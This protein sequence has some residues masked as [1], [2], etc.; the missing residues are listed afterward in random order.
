[1]GKS[2]L[3]NLKSKIF[4]YGP[5]GSGKSTLGIKL[6]ESLR[7]P[8]YD[9]DEHIQSEAGMTIPEI[10]Q[11]ESEAGFRR[12]EKAQLE[13]VLTKDW[14]VIALGGGAMLDAASRKMASSAGPVL[15]LAAPFETLLARLAATSEER[16]LL[17]T[18]DADRDLGAG[19]RAL[20]AQ[21]SEHYATFPLQLDTSS[22]DTASLVWEAQILLGTFHVS[23][24]AS[25]AGGIPED[26][27]GLGYDVR[28]QAGGLPALGEALRVRGLRGPIA[29][30]SDENVAALHLH[31]PLKS[32]HEAGYPSQPIVVPAGEDSKDIST[33]T[34]LWEAF[35]E[36]G[37]ERGSTVVALG[38]GVVGDLAGFAAASYKRGVPWVA[39]PTTL[40]AMADSSLGGKTG[41]D[42]RQGKNLVG[43]FH[44]PRL[45]LSDPNTLDTLPE[46]ELRAG[47]AEV[48][49]AGIIGDPALFNKC[50]EGWEAVQS[51]WDE[52]VRRA[53]AVK[54]RVIE[55]D[56]FEHGPRAALNLGHTVGHAVEMAAN[57]AMKHGQAV[58]IGMVVEAHLA[59]RVGLAEKGLAEE[60]A[61]VLRGLGLPTEVPAGL[62]KRAILEG[63]QVDKK[64]A[65]GK[66]R[67]ALPVRVGEVRVGVEVEH[68]SELEEVW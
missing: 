41:I 66:V 3:H 2:V 10:F 29:L 65:G 7:L 63:M 31:R 53:M 32:L 67:F 51:D 50:A 16:P 64:R 35:L 59:E 58:A 54:I 47:L 40:L 1:M 68:L 22:A 38:G 46:E 12:R 62:D 5:P 11:E 18:N 19:L 55:A 28:V 17:V 15:C 57:F 52:V 61:G 48:V 42:L 8:F 25:S 26:P 37:L 21:R 30:V 34:F 43:A 45:V 60:I 56:P 24:M 39:A 9:L 36:M 13:K 20:L 27:R 4:L 49:K 14:G 44:A 33:L 6:A 23:S